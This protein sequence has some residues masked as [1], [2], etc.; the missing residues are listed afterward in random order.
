MESALGFRIFWIGKFSGYPIDGNRWSENRLINWY[1]SIKLVNWYRS[2]DDQSITTQ[3]VFIDCYRLAQQPSNRCHA[4][5][6]SDHPPFLG[7]PGDE[8][9]HF[10]IPHNVP[11]LPPKF[12]MSIVFNFSW[13]SCNT[14]EK[15][16]T[17]VMQ[18]FGGQIRCI[19]GIVDVAYW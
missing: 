18:N 11:Y 9:R 1:Q 2:I 19:M 6:L 13:N 12:C 8:I 4:H 16:K 17:K 15:W 10:H 14:Q 7:S 3:K 5:Y